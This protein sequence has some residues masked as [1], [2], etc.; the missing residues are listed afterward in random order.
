MSA[1]DRRLDALEAQPRRCATCQ[2]RQGH[3]VIY[4]DAPAPDV[5]TDPCERCGWE[6]LVISVVHVDGAEW[7]RRGEGVRP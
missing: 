1:F 2:D 4:D 6:P 5:S 7:H 3:I